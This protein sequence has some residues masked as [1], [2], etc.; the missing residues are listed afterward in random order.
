ME[1]GSEP[2]VHYDVSLD[3]LSRWRFEPIGVWSKNE[4][5]RFYAPE[6]AMHVSHSILNLQRTEDFFEADC[7]TVSSLM[8]ANGHNHIDLLKLDIEGAEYEVLRSILADNIKPTLLCVEFDE[9]HHP[10]DDGAHD[11]IS[12]ALSDIS[13]MGY[14]LVHRSDWDFTFIQ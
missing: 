3:A 13:S 5:K 2:S 10:L 8:R 6:N 11:R 12:T 4:T 9:G 7:R 1:V 14:W